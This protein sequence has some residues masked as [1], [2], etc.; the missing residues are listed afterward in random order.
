VAQQRQVNIRLEDSDFEAL[1]AAAF[2]RRRS[3][4]EELRAAVLGH[5][6]ESQDDPRMAQAQGLRDELP[7]EDAPGEALVS[8]L[9]ARRRG[10][11]KGNA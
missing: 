5:L 4:P 2:I 6:A 10:G 7:V 11:R 8:S 9:D 3:V 1:E